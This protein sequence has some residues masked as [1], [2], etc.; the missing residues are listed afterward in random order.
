MYCGV[1]AGFNPYLLKF[2][3]TNYTAD[4]S[5]HINNALMMTNNNQLSYGWQRSRPG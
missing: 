2:Y 5:D 4:Q 1:Q 3:D